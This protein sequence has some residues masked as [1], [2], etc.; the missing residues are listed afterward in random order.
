MNRNWSR[1]QLFA[2][3]CDKAS[4]QD[5]AKEST[6]VTGR[7]RFGDFKID[8]DERIVALR[9]HELRLTS[10]EF[11]VLVFLASHPRSL[12][13]PQTM[14]ARS[15]TANQLGQTKFLTTL[16]SL[17]KKLDAAGHGKHYLQTEPLVIYRFDPTASSA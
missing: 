16:I 3:T 11:D 17:R 12:V 5:T 14:L 7:I 10:E 8:L 9:D 1:R 2:K 4:E 13:T 15:S 6:S